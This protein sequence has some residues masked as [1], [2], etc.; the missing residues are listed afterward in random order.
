[1]IFAAFYGL[2]AAV[3]WGVS[4]FLSRQPSRRIGYYVTSTLVQLFSFIGLTAYVLLANP[5]SLQK[6]TG[7][8][9][10]FAENLVV[11][12]LMFGA[13]LF[14]YRGYADGMMSIT[15]PIASSYPVIT[16]VLS[17]IVLGITIANVIVIGIT[18]VVAGIILAGIRLSELR[19]LIGGT[20]IGKMGVTRLTSRSNVLSSGQ[21]KRAILV[22]GVD[23]A[24]IACLFLGIIYLGLGSIT[25]VFGA[26][27]PILVMRGSATVV[28]FALL[29]P[30][31]QKFVLP[32]SVLPWI[33]LLA[34][35]DSSGLLAFDQGIS[36]AQ[37]NL[38]V[39][40][41]LSGLVGA[42]TL[43]LAR[44]AYKERLDK[45]QGIGVL[46]LLVGVGIVL[47]F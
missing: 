44:A 35:L 9:T 5:S 28:G 7:N 45:I 23:S 26:I 16:I 30:L 42:V 37:S 1:M 27:L 11:G 21:G 47:Y 18:I 17:V 12:V 33:L 22:K 4:D 19:Y 31:K 24:I 3:C 25:R 34:L 13:L 6:I 29:V 2:G 10:V 39:V 15:A 14:L 40:V 20:Q 38:P 8:T 43:L 36:A 41:T 46:V 32:K